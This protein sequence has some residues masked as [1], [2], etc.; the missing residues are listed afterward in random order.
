V[1]EHLV[2]VAASAAGALAQLGR[3]GL[4]DLV[5]HRPGRPQELDLAGRLGGGQGL[6]VDLGDLVGDA[7]VGR[8][9]ALDPLHDLE[10]LTGLGRGG[11]GG[12][13][14]LGHLGVAGGVGGQGL[15]G[16]LLGLA[17]P[18]PAG[19][20]DRAGEHLLVARLHIHRDRLGHGR[21]FSR[22]RD[23]LVGAAATLVGY[24]GVA[25]VRR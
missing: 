23:T 21:I 15:E 17:G 4:G 7:E 9:L 19:E 1:D 10:A 12:L 6:G 22:H 3:G 11:E 16:Q 25:G 24:A 5:E 8:A 20:V 13:G 18:A 14:P 2:A